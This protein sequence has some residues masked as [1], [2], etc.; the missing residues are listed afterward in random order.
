MRADRRLEEDRTTLD[1]LGNVIA[2]ARL[3]GS[4]VA[5]ITGGDPLTRPDRTRRLLEGLS[6]HKSIVVDTS[7]VGER[8]VIEQFVDALKE[9]RAHI[10]VSLDSPDSRVQNKI[11]PP[12]LKILKD[13][14]PH[15]TTLYTIERSLN[16]GL[17]LTVQTV[18]SRG[19]D[20]VEKLVGLRDFLL[21]I[22]VRHWVLHLAV[23]AGAAREVERRAKGGRGGI[24]PQPSARANVWRLVKDTVANALP[25]DIRVTDNDN[26]PN[27]VLLLGSDGTLYTEGLAHKGKVP[28]F[29]PE[30]GRPDLVRRLFFY[31]DK[32]GH[33]QRYLNWNA[34]MFDGRNLEDICFSVD[35]PDSAD[36]ESVGGLVERERKYAV[37]SEKDLEL[38]LAD[39]GYRLSSDDI[40]DDRYYDISESTLALN[41]FVLRL[42]K[43]NDEAY[44]AEKGPRYRRSD[45]EYD[46][47]ELELPIGDVD[48][49]ETEVALK[50]LRP[51][52]RL[53]R[54]RSVFRTK[55]KAPEVVIDRLTSV[56]TFMEMEGRSSE[57]ESL[58][59]K[60]KGLGQQE[61]RNYKDL[62]LDWCRGQRLD[63]EEVYGLDAKGILIRTE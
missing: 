63:A 49:F 40:I 54:R 48:R 21:G 6:G 39:A 33:A 44:M 4:I 32:F 29:D 45:G 18:V 35:L 41:D 15:S 30:W 14:N 36:D 50:G 10:R 38:S 27:S 17:P 60:L 51:S 58:V 9:H 37:A 23:E 26:T 7:G 59:G 55:T 24:L 43:V 57:M 53:E 16:A 13:G 12:N 3:V 31:I 5:V 19:N 34:E 1:Q 22:G 2:T 56:G 25:I 20:T 42:R 62:V 8:G 11:R 46:R 47:V 52:W 28:L 61:T